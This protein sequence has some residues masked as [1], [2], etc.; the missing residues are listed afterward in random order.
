M[1]RNR[2]GVVDMPVCEPLAVSFLVLEME[3][4]TSPLLAR[5]DVIMSTA[6][7]FDPR[8]VALADKRK[9]A[10]LCGNFCSARMRFAIPFASEHLGSFVDSRMVFH[11][12]V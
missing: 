7:L 3:D 12:S 5:V 2:K 8:E 4:H 9:L 1:P 10:F 11:T 6:F